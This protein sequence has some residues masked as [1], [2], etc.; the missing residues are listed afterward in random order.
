V[1][2]PGNWMTARNSLNSL[3]RRYTEPKLTDETVSV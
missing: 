2:L 3:T 1:L